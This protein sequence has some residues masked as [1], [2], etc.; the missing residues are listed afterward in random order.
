VETIK[1]GYSVKLYFA[2]LNPMQPAKDSTR[3]KI[4][5]YTVYIRRDY[6]IQIDRGFVF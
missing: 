4:Q 3:G 5:G 2:E 1:D 6:Q